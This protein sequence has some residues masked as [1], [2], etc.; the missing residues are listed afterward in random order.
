MPQHVLMYIQEH[1]QHGRNANRRT[2]ARSR[3]QQP[4][5]TSNLRH[6]GQI[7]PLPRMCIV[8]GHDVPVKLPMHKVVYAAANIK[9][10]LSNQPNACESHESY[11]ADPKPQGTENFEPG[12]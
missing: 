2:P 3:N 4:Y 10:R 6:S 8:I 11:D 1:H 12:W 5:P 9:Q 7:H